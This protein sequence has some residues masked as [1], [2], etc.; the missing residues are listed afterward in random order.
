MLAGLDR[1]VQGA[2]LHQAQM[3]YRHN[4]TAAWKR[5]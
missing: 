2:H 3:G 4:A 5:I 1:A